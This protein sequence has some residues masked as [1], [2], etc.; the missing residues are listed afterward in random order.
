MQLDTERQMRLGAIKIELAN[1]FFEIA[2][3]FE[4]RD[5]DMPKK[6]IAKYPGLILEALEK[7]EVDAMAEYYKEEAVHDDV[8]RMEMEAEEASRNKPE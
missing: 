7:V 3:G 8:R 2:L 1:L 5:T 4:R 6:L